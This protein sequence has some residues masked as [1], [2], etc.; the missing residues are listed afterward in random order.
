VLKVLNMPTE[1]VA[2]E[3]VPAGT[4]ETVRGSVIED[5]GNFP[6]GSE[7]APNGGGINN[8]LVRTGTTQGSFTGEYSTVV[9]AG[10]PNFFIAFRFGVVKGGSFKFII[11]PEGLPSPIAASDS[12]L[13]IRSQ[14]EK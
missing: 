13:L 4:P 14:P 1:L 5:T 9:P 2:R 10:G 7:L 8:S 12:T 6:G 11:Q 3:S